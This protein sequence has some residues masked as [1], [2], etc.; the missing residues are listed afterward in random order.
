MHEWALLIMTV[1]VPAAVGGFLFL[2]AFHN[3]LTKAGQD[4]YKA[5][6]L[7]ILSL[8]VLSLVGLIASFFHLGTPTHAFY[9]ILGFGRSW[10]SNEI[11]F[12]GAFIALACLTA[13]LVFVQKKTN[14]ILMIVTGIVGLAAVFCM[15]SIYAATRVNGWDNV[16]T[17]LVFFGT[18]FTLGPVLAAGLLSVTIKG[19]SLK[20][21]VKWAF[22]ITIFGIGI[23]VIGTA[24]LAVS[25]ADIEMIKGATAFESLSGYGTMITF[26]WVLEII[27]LALLGFLSLTSVKKAGFALIYAAVA[28]LIIG[29]G[30]SRYV[31]YVLGA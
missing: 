5:M 22:A 29:E 17:Y 24:L 20:S 11:V 6:K 13:L 26:R 18:V 30:M 23:Q 14:P 15:A 3:K 27:G 12:T 21:I 19:D 25:S 7:P 10:M 1:C 2:G 8:G 31:F 16:N 28:V 4:N 9:T